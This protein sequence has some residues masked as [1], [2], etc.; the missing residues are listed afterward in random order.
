ML[1]ARQQGNT[2]RREA[3]SEQPPDIL[4]FDLMLR[5]V[6]D[7]SHACSFSAQELASSH[8]FGLVLIQ[9]SRLFERL[10]TRMARMSPVRMSGMF[11]S[12]VK[13]ARASTFKSWPKLRSNRSVRY[14]P[15]PTASTLDSQ[16]R[17][18]EKKPSPLTS[19]T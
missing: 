14:S 6:I 17:R 5:F 18:E 15:P 3:T 10:T 9:S 1:T 16:L 8:A 11:L 13:V 7:M 2:T 4:R 12:L 19:S